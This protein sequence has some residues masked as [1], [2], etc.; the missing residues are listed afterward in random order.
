MA[1][2]IRG[3]GKLLLAT[4]RDAMLLEDTDGDSR[5]DRRSFL[6]RLET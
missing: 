1:I 4:R 5:S 3:E 2:A 6:A